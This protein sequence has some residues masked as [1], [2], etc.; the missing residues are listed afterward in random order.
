VGRECRQKSNTPC[1]WQ[2]ISRSKRD[3]GWGLKD[4][5]TFNVALLASSFWRAVSTVSIW[6]TIIM[7]KYLE[8]KPLLHWLR[9]QTVQL[10]RASSFWKGL[11]NS[12]PVIQHWLCWMPGEGREILLGRDVILG[13]GDRSLLSSAM[14]IHLRSLNLNTLDQIRTVSAASLLPDVWL[15][16]SD[17]LLSEPLTTEWNRFTSALKGAGISLKAEPDVLS[18]AGGDGSGLI[19]AKNL[20]N[21]LQNRFYTVPC[22]P[23]T[24]KLWKLQLPLKLKL[25][26]W[27]VGNDKLLT[28]EV[29]KGVAGWGRV[30]VY[31]AKLLLRTYFI[32]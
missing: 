27:L 14:R 4:L 13:L 18:W 28:W 30:F 19:S 24:N 17:L 16:S 6:H 1:K 32:F 12:S 21:A 26:S 20:Y 11:V 29:Y 25:F 23:W 5:T 15:S 2:A 8:S 10:T 9:K 31:F 7:D 22:L 3:G